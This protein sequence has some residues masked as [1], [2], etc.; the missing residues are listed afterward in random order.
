VSLC[1]TLFYLFYCFLLQNQTS[2]QWNRCFLLLSA[3][4][5]F[6]LPLLQIP[7]VY[8]YETIAEAPTW[9]YVLQS[10]SIEAEASQRLQQNMGLVEV[11]SIIYFTGVLLF[12]FR[13]IGQ[14]WSFGHFVQKHKANSV[15]TEKGY[16]LIETQ[17]L[18]TFS[19]FKYLVINTQQLPQ[20][21]KEQI[22][23]HEEAH[24]EQ[25]HSYDILLFEALKAVCWFNPIVYL[26]Q[27][28]LQEVHE[29]L[30]D[31][32][33]LKQYPLN[34]K[35]YSQLIVQ[36][37]IHCNVIQISNHFSKHQIKK[38]ILMMKNTQTQNRTLWTYFLAIPLLGLSFLLFSCSKAESVEKQTPISEVVAKKVADKG[39]D[40]IYQE[41]DQ[42]PEF[43]GGFEELFKFMGE[44]VKYPKSAIE[45][46]AE[47]KT[48]I[49]FVVNEKGEIT[50]ANI[51]KGFNPNCDAE[52]LRVI[53]AMPNWT[54][55]VHEGKKVKVQFT[56]PISFQLEDNN[57]E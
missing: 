26:Y 56:L 13:L 46:K 39:K 48:F 10:I 27:Q 29:Y 11:L 24:I 25:L 3:V 20:L 40:G 6:V 9:S 7:L 41:V 37:A 28:K 45:A 23:L 57:T 44:N 34:R 54:S 30:A 19:F 43:P 5:A 42:M 17:Q 31:S 12:S 51:L 33:V 53:N 32:V 8:D 2:L 21:A 52:A 55:G 35:T 18:P 36:Q 38:R 1:M 16:H 49:A 4:T 47:G 14:L 15:V 50:D 22:L